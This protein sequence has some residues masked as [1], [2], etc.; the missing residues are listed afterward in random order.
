MTIH[1][2]S[3][4]I[5]DSTE[6]SPIPEMVGKPMIQEENLESKKKG[7]EHDE[8]L[9]LL[10]KDVLCDAAQSSRKFHLKWDIIVTYVELRSHSCIWN[11]CLDL[12][13]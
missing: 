2:A 8:V 10:S 13:T 9:L 5:T 3:F 1:L 12:L 4:L 6:G 7:Y 11:L